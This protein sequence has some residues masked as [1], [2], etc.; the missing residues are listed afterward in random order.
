MAVHTHAAKLA[1][2]ELDQKLAELD[3]DDDCICPRH[4]LG[5]L[6]LTLKLINAQIP[7][8]ESPAC[9]SPSRGRVCQASKLFC[10]NRYSSEPRVQSDYPPLLQRTHQ[11]RFC[12][13]LVIELA[14]QRIDSAD[15]VQ[16]LIAP[17][18]KKDEDSSIVQKLLGRV[19]LENQMRGNRKA[20]AASLARVC[21]LGGIKALAVLAELPAFACPATVF[22]LAI[23]LGAEAAEGRDACLA[24]AKQHADRL[25]RKDVKVHKTAITAVCDALALITRSAKIES[26]TARHLL[27]KALHINASASNV[28]SNVLSN[29]PS[30]V[31]PKALDIDASADYNDNKYI[32]A[33]INTTLR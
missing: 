1:G 12:V 7:G 18:K 10:S 23:H 19:K 21:K 4:V 33:Y 5:H 13:R 2:A 20:L 16:A 31:P 26:G 27:Q 14:R 29:I 17:S 15:V 32:Y 3:A 22:V 6:L 30:N 8:Y 25:K 28:S 9:C 11:L 24:E